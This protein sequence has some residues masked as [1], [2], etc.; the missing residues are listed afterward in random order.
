[1]QK[2]RI[3]FVEDE[4]LKDMVGNREKFLQEDLVERDITLSRKHENTGRPLGGDSFM[5]QL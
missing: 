1:M 3:D 2:E 4:M 5:E